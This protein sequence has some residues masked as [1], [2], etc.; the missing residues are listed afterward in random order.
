MSERWMYSK[1]C[2]YNWWK[3]ICRYI[4][5]I[6][7]DNYETKCEVPKFNKSVPLKNNLHNS[8]ISGNLFSKNLNTDVKLFTKKKPYKCATYL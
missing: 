4:Y 8:Q 1:I 5:T 7:H 2:T 3:R 6:T